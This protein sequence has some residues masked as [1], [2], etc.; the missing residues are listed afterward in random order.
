M[1]KIN[2]LKYIIKKCD[3]KLSIWVGEWVIW[4]YFAETQ[5]KE[6][7]FIQLTTWC[8]THSP[9]LLPNQH[10]Q[11]SSHREHAWSLTTTWQL[12]FLMTNWN[13]FTKKYTPFVL[14]QTD[15]LISLFRIPAEKHTWNFLSLTHWTGS[16][17]WE[18]CE[19]TKW[20]H[21]FRFP[22]KKHFSFIIQGR[23]LQLAPR[24]TEFMCTPFKKKMFP[25]ILLLQ[26]I[27][28]MG[29]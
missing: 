4:H 23:F 6:G 16:A 28:K 21:D 24:D 22:R 9:A 13:Y 3:I 26:L 5:G 18:D 2:I 8:P 15:N 29:G 17:L 25:A 10:T 1:I 20:C 27:D 19:Q 7:S 14:M 12:S 11:L